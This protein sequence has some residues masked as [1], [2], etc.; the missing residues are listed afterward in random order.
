MLFDVFESQ[1]KRYKCMN[2]E[3]VYKQLTFKALQRL[4]YEH[5]T[6]PK[7][8]HE[9]IR[10]PI[11]FDTKQTPVSQ[12]KI[13]WNVYGATKHEIRCLY[14]DMSRYTQKK[15]EMELY[16]QLINVL[17]TINENTLQNVE[18]CLKRIEKHN[19]AAIIDNTFVLCLQIAYVLFLFGYY[20]H[21][22]YYI[23]KLYLIRDMLD[24]SMRSRVHLLLGTIHYTQRRFQ[25]VLENMKQVTDKSFHLDVIRA[26]LS[27]HLMRFE[28]SSAY[29]VWKTHISTS[30]SFI[31]SKECFFYMIDMIDVIIESSP[32]P[33]LLFGITSFLYLLYSYKFFT[34]KREKKPPVIPSRPFSVPFI[35]LQDSP[36]Q[37]Q[38]DQFFTDAIVPYEQ[39]EPLHNK[40]KGKQAMETISDKKLQENA[41]YGQMIQLQPSLQATVFD[42]Y[43]PL[44]DYYEQDNK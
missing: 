11:R 40:V 44:R 29:Q 16:R 31:F 20:E 4:A 9:L 26:T 27:T 34:I 36:F 25:D 3:D 10:A 17:S 43:K 2:K 30:W 18:R 41:I 13:R 5:E 24:D 7:T 22:H 32:A 14:N 33:M 39:F 1:Q 12:L 38:D 37:E 35:P 19:A 23:G 42:Q 15:S 8:K 6:K 21:S 28:Y